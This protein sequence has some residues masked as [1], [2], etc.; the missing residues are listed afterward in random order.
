[1]FS[2]PAARGWFLFV[3][4]NARPPRR[5]NAELDDTFKKNCEALISLFVAAGRFRKKKTT[6]G[7]SFLSHFVV[8]VPV[9]FR[10]NIVD[11]DIVDRYS[12]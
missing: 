12:R 8:S 3:L 10:H 6:P 7:A 5:S 4:G 1:M 2:N 11:I 9:V